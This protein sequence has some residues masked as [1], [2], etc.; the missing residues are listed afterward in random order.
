MNKMI[1]WPVYLD[2]NKTRKEGRRIPKNI[3][4]PDPK[5]S[6]IKEACIK[7]GLDPIVEED[8][9]YPRS[10]WEKSGRVMVNRNATK[11]QTLKEIA[12]KILEQRKRDYDL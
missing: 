2:Y 11:T 1:V 5:V 10:W 6:E 3:A 9:R 8:K 7:L 12:R 4:V